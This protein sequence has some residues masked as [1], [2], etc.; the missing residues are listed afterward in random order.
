MQFI[1]GSA[2]QWPKKDSK[3]KINN[4]ELAIKQIIQST[5]KRFKGKKIRF[6]D[7][8]YNISYKRLRSSAGKTMLDS[9]I[10]RIET[11]QILIVDISSGNAN[12]FIELGIALYFSKNNKE[13]SVYFIKE[14]KGNEEIHNDLPSD[15]Q[16]YFITPY[17]VSNGKVTFKDNNSLLMS[18]SS[19]I[20]DYYN[21]IGGNENTDEV[22]FN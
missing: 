20:K 22:N 4:S 21:K 11:S 6:T 5:N 9:I 14:K 3:E 12:V 19:D 18:I 13:F 16:G 8:E 10:K 1:I 7:L 2:Y 17:Q 15:L